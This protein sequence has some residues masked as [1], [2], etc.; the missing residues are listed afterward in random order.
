MIQRKSRMSGSMM[1]PSMFFRPKVAIRSNSQ[2]QRPWIQSPTSFSGL[3]GR[4]FDDNSAF[5]VHLQ[6]G[7]PFRPQMVSW[8]T[9]QGRWPWLWEPLALWAEKHDVGNYPEPLTKKDI[10]STRVMCH[11]VTVFGH[12]VLLVRY[13][14]K[15]LLLRRLRSSGTEL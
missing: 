2:G 5:Q 1:L 4:P 7:R 10:P 12:A 14:E 6:N 3:K 13:Q 9:N 8:L 15:S 11:C